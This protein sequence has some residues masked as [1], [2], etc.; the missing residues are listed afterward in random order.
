MAMAG[1]AVA[2]FVGL[3]AYGL[4]SNAPDDRIRQRLAD[5]KAIDAPDFTLD[6]LAR[7][8]LGGFPRRVRALFQP[9]A[10]LSLSQLRGTPIMLNFWASWCDPCRTEAPILEAGWQ[11]TQR[12]GVLFLGLN[13]LDATGDARDFLDEFGVSY[14]TIR[15][16]TKETSARYGVTGFPET[17]FIDARGRVVAGVVGVINPGLL[18]RGIQAAR[19]GTVAGLLAGGPQGGTDLRLK[20]V[21]PSS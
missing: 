16:G 11:R 10:Q 4:L 5:R 6:V 21:Q 14:P 3:L 18:D 2:A 20:P 7:G 13:S 15:D 9:G 19:T 17:Y 8:D 1:L 12:S